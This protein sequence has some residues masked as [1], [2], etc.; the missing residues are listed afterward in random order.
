MIIFLSKIVRIQGAYRS[1]RVIVL[2]MI[3]FLNKIVRIQ[4]AYRGLVAATR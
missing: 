4:G 1:N 3:I 2:N